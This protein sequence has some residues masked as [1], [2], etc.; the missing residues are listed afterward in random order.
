MEYQRTIK[1]VVSL[2]GVSLMLGVESEIIFKPAPVNSGVIFV[3]T[4]L[5]DKPQIKADISN[6]SFQMPRCTSLKQKNAEVYIYSVEHLLSTL[7]GLRIDNITI[8]INSS[9]PPLIDGSALPFVE[10]IKKAEILDQDAPREYLRLEET[11]SVSEGNK[12]LIMIPSDPSESESGS[13]DFTATYCYDHPDFSDQIATF[14]ISE[15]NFIKEIAPARTFCFA[16]EIEILKAQ[17]LGK[18]GSHENV[19]VIAEDGKTN[20]P[21]RFPNEMVRHKILDLIGDLYLIGKI[22]AAHVIGVRSGHNLDAKLAQKVSES[23][24]KLQG[25]GKGVRKILDATEIQRILPHRYPFLLVDRIIEIEDETRAVG[26][27]NVTINEEFFQGHFPEKP[28][29]PAV[30]Q[31][32]ALAQVAGVLLLR[33]RENQGRLAYFMSWDNVKFRRPVVP[34]DQLR[35]EVE[36]VRLRHRAGKIKGKAYVEGN[37]TAEAEFSFAL[38][39]KE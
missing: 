24:S 39:D 8:E 17:G 21:L 22:P 16:H 29:M 25:K 10:A 7:I 32:E 28:V 12:H 4:D 18:G 33:K 19:V 34:G 2:S 38:T 23:F 9:E 14:S 27:K 26:L 37:L 13:T 35:L 31:V 3:R 6:L 15:E 11:I 1:S 20:R 5:P 36:V 30:L